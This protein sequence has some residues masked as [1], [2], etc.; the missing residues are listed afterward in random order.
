MY[1][2]R[3]EVSTTNQ[4][5]PAHIQFN[6]KP[7]VD[8]Q[9]LVLGNTYINAFNES[10]SVRSFKFYVSE[11]DLVNEV[12]GTTF[13]LDRSQFYLID[14]S[15]STS[16]SVAFNAPAN[17]YHSIAFTIGVDSIRNVSGAQ[18]GALDPAR[19]MFWTWNTGYI[20]A[21][22]EGYSPA[23]SQPNQLFEYHIG[24]FKGE[25]NVVKKLKLMLPAGTMIDATTGKIS[26]ISLSADVNKWFAGPVPISIA[27][28]PVCIM[29]GPLAKSIAGNYLTMFSVVQ[30]INR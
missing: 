21:K 17:Q 18:T 23:S 29:P 30:V 9:N 13:Q 7:V 10:F 5:K 16:L 12:S 14:V 25:N 15:D 26:T 4:D 20:M 2:C 24:G 11:I 22:L 28:S 27:N 8:G 1:A 6:F 19:G 3:K